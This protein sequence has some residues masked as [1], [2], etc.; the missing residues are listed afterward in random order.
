MVIRH[1]VFFVITMISL[2]SASID[3]LHAADSKTFSGTIAFVANVHGNWDLFLLDG[4]GLQPDQLTDTSFDERAPAI[5]PDGQRIVYSTSDG[6][7][8]LFSLATREHARLP[9]PKGQYHYPAWSSD[10]AS[11]LYTVYS[12][13]R[14]NEDADLWMYSFSD[15]THSSFLTQPGSQD[16]VAIAPIGENMVYA[17][18]SKAV[19]LGWGTTILQQLWRVSL[20][21]GRLVEIVS[22]GG[23]VTN[24]SWSP[25]G[26][27]I[28]FSSDRA[29]SPDLWLIEVHGKELFQLTDHSEAELHPSW[30]P[31]GQ[32]LAYI[33]RDD[34]GTR[35]KI[36][37]RSSGRVRELSPFV[38]QEVDIRDPDWK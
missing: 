17:S 7:L 36:L 26:K 29:G 23:S 19:L 13:S 25:D 11:I 22:A 28:V 15:E 10:G 32:E 38:L 24:P 30:S 16:Y 18:T 34:K 35:L 20:Q 37:D 3:V 27:T 8:W 1:M 5:S 31:D 33:S 9:L 12:G 14:G 2:L 21:D 6:A 4:N